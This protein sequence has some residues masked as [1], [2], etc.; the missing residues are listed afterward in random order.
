MPT[1]TDSARLRRLDS[2][3]A[4][5]VLGIR[6][7]HLSNGDEVVESDGVYATLPRYTRSLDAAW[8]GV[9]KLTADPK[10]LI[11]C[12][13]TG[14]SPMYEVN[15]MVGT[16]RWYFAAWGDYRPEECGETEY[17]AHPAEAL[18]LA[19]LRAVGVSEDELK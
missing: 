18:V 6:F 9:E 2:L 11:V 1:T 13:E 14:T 17:A 19:C 10:G 5:R 16:Q 15:T 3:F 4:E 8:E 12:L 7:I